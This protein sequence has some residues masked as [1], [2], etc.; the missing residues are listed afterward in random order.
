MP[1]KGTK[2]EVSLREIANE[3][4]L[5]I[6]TISRVL[7]K[8][9][10]ISDKTR[11]KVLN[12]AK[13][14]RY[15]P[16]MLV[17]GIQTGKTHTMGVMVPP[18]DSYWTDVLYG[19]HDELTAANHVYINAWCELEQEDD[20]YSHILLK[21]LHDMIDRRVD[22]IILWPHLAPLYP[23][24]I[25]ELEARD[26]PVV[27]IDHELPFA[28]TVETD[29][30]SGAVQ[31]ARH[32]LELG[33]RRFAHLAWDDSYKWAQLRRQFFEQTVAHS[34][35]TCL[36]IT[37]KQDEDVAIVTKK[38]LSTNPRPTALFACS[39]RIAQLAYETIKEMGL[40]IPE[41]ISVV[42][43]ADLEFSRWMQP[44]LTTVKQNGKEI[45]KAAGKLLIQRSEGKLEGE[46][47]RI[48][49]K[50][51]LINRASTAPPVRDRN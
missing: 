39:D 32:L 23:E 1:P 41:D 18:Y 17:K 27:T 21:R 48:R 36:T 4:G 51:E 25:E 19:I 46:P 2:S 12:T 44:A 14:M 40:R 35:S 31:V 8:Q 3:T 11:Q 9:G 22:G 47:K 29:E 26:L 24:H 16:N 43:F 20:S 50:C 10:E 30:E 28:D 15:R 37:A 5:S 33:H 38:L 45:G 13:R 49:V 6:T 7:R 42:G 34:D